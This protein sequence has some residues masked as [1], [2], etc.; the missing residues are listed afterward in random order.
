MYDSVMTAKA[1]KTEQRNIREWEL[2]GSRYRDHLR[3][4]LCRIAF[5]LDD[6]PMPFLVGANFCIKA[7]AE[8]CGGRRSSGGP[9]A[10]EHSYV[11]RLS[12]HT[13]WLLDCGRDHFF[14]WLDSLPP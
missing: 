4:P 6:R 10:I 14:G 8:Q 13:R 12:R 7:R 3:R 1:K 9:H 2:T 5:S 11:G